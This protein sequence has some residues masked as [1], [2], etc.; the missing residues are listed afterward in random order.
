L[1]RSGGADYPAINEL[2]DKSI[3]SSQNS[4][5]SIVSNRFQV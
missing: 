2:A 4:P 5:F 1:A 3:H